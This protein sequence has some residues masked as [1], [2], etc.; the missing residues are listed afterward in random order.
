MEGPRPDTASAR[1]VS[2]PNPRAWQSSVSLQRGRVQ[3]QPLPPR[4]VAHGLST[5]LFVSRLRSLAGPSPT[6]L[7][8]GPAVDRVS[9][10]VAA[11]SRFGATDRAGSFAQ[12]IAIPEVH[13]P[14]EY[15][16]NLRSVVTQKIP[17]FDPESNDKQGYVGAS[18]DPAQYATRPPHEVDEPVPASVTCVRRCASASD[19]GRKSEN[20]GDSEST[21]ERSLVERD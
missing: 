16:V 5:S 14:S 18:R 7:R 2:T 17:Q 4:L 12:A 20:R 1:G 19:W 6:E 13:D 10:D 21:A 9:V 8:E 15:W 3:T 11:N